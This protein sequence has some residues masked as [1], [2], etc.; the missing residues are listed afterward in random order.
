[1]TVPF[2]TLAAVDLGSNS[3]RLQIV[4]V[5][6]GGLFPIDSLKDTVRLGAGLLPNGN[7]D[8]A[9]AARALACLA[10][11]GER[12]RGFKPD[13]VRVVG[14]N[15]LRVANHAEA[16]IAQAEALLGFPIEII[17]GREEARLIYLGAAHSLPLSPEKR[18]VV[19]I[20][21][22]STE[23]IIGQ[24]MQAL[25]TES[26]TMGCVSYSLRFFPDG[27]MTRSR[28]RDAEL[29][30]R[31]QVQ[32]IA[33]DF[34]PEH[35]QCAIGTSGT[36]RSLRDILE[37]SDFS[38]EGIT[39]EGMERLRH[40]LIKIGQMQD[41]TL[42]GLREDRAPVLPGGLAIMLAVFEELQVQRMGLTLGALRDG[43]LYDLLGREEACDPR[44]KTV[45]FMMRR[46]HVEAAQATRVAR[47]AQRFYA[48][49][50]P[51]PADSEHE[52][53]LAW[54]AQLH[55][56]GLD[57][58][59]SGFHKHAAYIVENSDMPGFSRR[60]QQRLA[61]LIM[62][63]RGSLT[64][65]ANRVGID[66]SLW[67]AILSLRLAALLSRSRRDPD[68][69]ATFMASSDSGHVF[70]LVFEPDWLKQHPL[71]ATALAEEAVRWKDIGF[72]LL[73]PQ[74][75]AEPERARKGS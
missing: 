35:W 65:L 29:A 4:R 73:I 55:E 33:R 46:Y 10:R 27:R 6:E 7:L 21:G 54:A 39:L 56:V 52:R 69:P 24:G 19:D 36:A 63:Q 9:V 67:P 43:V 2:E 15:T 5:T 53:E 13:R 44:A 3:F 74:L 62:A 57:I 25:R 50:A 32:R 16:F 18:L 31:D 1:M 71:T 11:F 26:L 59:H 61:T 75:L 47:L 60:E 22:G 38:E 17:A 66:E 23:F 8:D 14:T 34:S 51:Y 70:R 58:S 37:Q 45:D 64:K 20:G 42:K 40:E 48:A 41:V 12:L 68:F 72:E 49:L 30:A 28:F